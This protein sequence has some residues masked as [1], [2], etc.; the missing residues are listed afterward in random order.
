MFFSLLAAQ[1]LFWCAVLSSSPKANETNNAFQNCKGKKDNCEKPRPVL[2][3]LI[4][5]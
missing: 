1:P 3:C 5:F 2:W 4:V